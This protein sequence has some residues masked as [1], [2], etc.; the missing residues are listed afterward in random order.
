M[1]TTPADTI[2]T[3]QTVIREQSSTDRVKA[4]AKR[5]LQKAR[6]EQLQREC[7]PMLRLSN[8]RAE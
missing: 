6:T 5:T 1:T 4:W 8:G 3:M 7:A 2:K